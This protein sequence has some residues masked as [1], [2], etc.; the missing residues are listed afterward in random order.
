MGLSSG[1]LPRGRLPLV[2]PS[3]PQDGN[4]TLR[5]S[6]TMTA[7]NKLR[8]RTP[9]PYLNSGSLH[10]MIVHSNFTMNKFLSFLVAVLAIAQTSAFMGTPVFGSQA[11]RFEFLRNWWF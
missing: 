6:V 4:R 9:R 1:V 10:L 8:S 11:V 5:S 3:A 7:I 2:R